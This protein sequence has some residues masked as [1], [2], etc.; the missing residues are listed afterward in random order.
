MVRIFCH[1]IVLV[2]CCWTIKSSVLKAIYDIMH[3]PIITLAVTNQLFI[4]NK[5]TFY[6]ACTPMFIVVF[7]TSSL[8]AHLKTNWET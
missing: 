8:H 3:V 4:L 1:T 2:S 7:N 6:N 5:T